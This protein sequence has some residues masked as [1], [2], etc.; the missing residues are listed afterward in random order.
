MFPSSIILLSLYSS[1]LSFSILF[2][3]P[4]FLQLL[5]RCPNPPQFCSTVEPVASVLI[6]P[7]ASFSFFYSLQ[8]LF[9][10]MA[11]SYHCLIELGCCSDSMSLQ[12]IVS[13]I[14]CLNSSINGLLSYLLSLAALL[15]SYMNSSIIFPSYSSLFNSAIFDLSLS[16]PPNSFLIFA[17]NSPAVLYSNNLASKSSS[18]F[19]FQTSANLSCTYDSTH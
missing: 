18:I 12:C 13:F 2:P 10:A 14:P 6:V 4:L 9:K 1:L 11:Q 8:S 15:N 19:F 3:I 17:K 7:S 5:A 16:S